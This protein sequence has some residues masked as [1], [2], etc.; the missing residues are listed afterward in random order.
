MVGH[1]IGRTNDGRTND[2]RTNDGRT[3]DSTPVVADQVE[4]EEDG[5]MGDVEQVQ[6]VWGET[7]S[8][9][10]LGGEVKQL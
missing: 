4:L 5:R 3:N 1:M 10:G 9:D 8:A 2:G 7:P 6:R